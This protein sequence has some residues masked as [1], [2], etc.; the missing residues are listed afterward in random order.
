MF[1]F[2]RG[3]WRGVWAG[4]GAGVGV[5]G[6]SF[7]KFVVISCLQRVSRSVF[8]G[9]GCAAGLRAD[10]FVI[11]V[12]GLALGGALSLLV[13]VVLSADVLESTT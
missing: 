13:F 5:L 1:V 3:A 11:C 10:M 9:V 8:T 6:G 7:M 4:V 12:A 2:L